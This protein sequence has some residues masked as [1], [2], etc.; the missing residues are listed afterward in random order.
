MNLKIMEQTKDKISFTLSD[1]TAAYANTLRRLMLSEVPTMAIDDVTFYKNDSV[2]FDE[3]L[4]HR[5]G[6]IVLKTDLKSYNMSSVCSC[7]GVGCAQCQLKLT[8]EV[9]GPRTVYAKDLVSSDPKVV[10]VYPETI[11]TKLLEG[12]K[13]KLEAVAK[14]GLGKEHSKWNPGLVWYYN[15]PT[16]KVNN[17]SKKFD[18]FKDK[19]PPQVFNKKGEI[20]ASLI[21]TPQLMDA[22]SDVETDIVSITYNPNSFVFILES[23]GFL[24]PKEIVLSA[25][26]MF[27][28]QLD[29]FVKLVKE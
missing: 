26:E 23:F 29:T 17:K 19:F 1:V 13:L 24:T 14:L 27:D 12:Q 20:D 28:K 25:I 15:E 16:I 22:C 4:A 21:N 2:L 18:E 5:L 9:E 6:L 11:I 10:P 8:M 3:I 7:K